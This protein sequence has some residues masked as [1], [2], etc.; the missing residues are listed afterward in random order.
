LREANLERASL[1][2][3]YLCGADFT[4]AMLKDADLKGAWYDLT[5]RWPAGFDPKAAGAKSVE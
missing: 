1:A 2:G 5:T 4:G 3:A